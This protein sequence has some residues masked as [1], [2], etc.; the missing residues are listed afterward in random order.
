MEIFWPAKSSNNYDFLF[1]DFLVLTMDKLPYIFNHP[2]LFRCCHEFFSN[3]L[4]EC[5]L[6]RTL[7]STYNGFP[8]SLI[9]F[10]VRASPQ[11]HPL[12]PGWPV[13]AKLFPDITLGVPFNRVPL[14]WVGFLG[15]LTLHSLGS[16]THSYEYTLF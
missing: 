13:L 6:P 10:L 5:T 9:L 2:Q 15:F 4:T 16:I 1:Q 7:F 12:A 8:L 3:L 11:P 14:A